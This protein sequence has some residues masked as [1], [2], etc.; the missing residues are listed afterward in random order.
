SAKIIGPGMLPVRLSEFR[1]PMAAKFRNPVPGQFL[2]YTYQ[3]V[4]VSLRKVVPLDQHRLRG[5]A[6]VD[7][8]QMLLQRSERRDPSREARPVAGT[9]EFERVPEAFGEQPEAMQRLEG[10]IR[11]QFAAGFEKP[12]RQF[13]QFLAGIFRNALMPL[14]MDLDGLVQPLGFS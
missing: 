2:Q 13:R 11:R 7:L 3:P 12:A 5:G 10:R 14:P 8:A 6:I 9:E 1:L 4:P